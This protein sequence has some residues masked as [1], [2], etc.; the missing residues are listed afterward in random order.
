VQ[1]KSLRQILALV[2]FIGLLPMTLLLAL[3]IYQGQK[4]ARDESLADLNGL[5]QALSKQYEL[6]IADTEYVFQSLGGVETIKKGDRA[7]CESWLAKNLPARP[8]INTWFRL[9]P[10]GR[11]TCASKAMG[12]DAT[13]D[14]VFNPA[15]PKA[16]N[17]IRMSQSR[18]SASTGKHVL[19][20]TKTYWNDGAP[21]QLLVTLDVD[22]FLKAAAQYV[23]L[24]DRRV[25]IVSKDG[26]VLLQLPEY[27]AAY[28]GRAPSFKRIAVPENHPIV[29]E[30]K[31]GVDGT[32]R[33]VS[34]V[35]M[36]R[37]VDGRPLF[38]S[39]SAKPEAINARANWFIL[40]GL[41][42]LILGIIGVVI[43]QRFLFERYLAKPIAAIVTYSINAAQHKRNELIELPATAPREFSEIA[44]AV[45][46]MSNENEERS[47][48]LSE[49]LQNLERAQDIAKMG[50]WRIDLKSNTLDWSDGVY[51]LHKLERGTFEPSVERAI[52]L[53]HPED[54]DDV[55]RSIED[56][57]RK[58]QPF[59]FEKRIVRSD[60][61]YLYI[62]SRGQL[63][64]NSQGDPIAMFGTI[65]D[66]D[67]PKQAQRELKRAQSAAQR[68]ADTRASFV[69][70]V[71]HEVRTPLTAM[72]GIVD[73]FRHEELTAEQLRQVELLDASG[74]MLMTVI[75]DLLDSASVDAGAIRLVERPADPAA[76]VDSCYAIFQTAYRSTGVAFHHRS[77]GQAPQT[78]IFD[79][80]RTRQII[81][82]LL[83]NAFK[84]T[85]A[86]EIALETTFHADKML[87]SVRDTG[88][89]IAEAKQRHVFERF[90][91]GGDADGAQRPGTGLGLSIVKAIVEQMGGTIRLAS[92]QGQGSCFTVDIPFKSADAA[93]PDYRPAAPREKR[94]GQV[95]LVED[96]PVNQKLLMAFLKK[97]GCSFVVQN[98][99]QYAVEWLLAQRQEDLPVLA[100][101]DVNM[102]RLNGIELCEFIRT[103][104]PGGDQMPLYLVTADVIAGHDN[105][106]KKLEINGTIPK[107]I[108]FAALR[109]VVQ[110]YVA[111]QRARPAA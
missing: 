10:D 72:L 22:W 86:G 62:S 20:L 60:G 80:Q 84:H 13:L 33:F 100:L 56:A 101:I 21:F 88:P 39:V 69:A 97:I 99:G 27:N 28:R 82:N 55:Q 107:P 65:I 108:D 111:P 51:K 91:Q 3:L 63:T 95:L 78:A 64:F 73:G 7:A 25:F 43:A 98:D 89:G 44:H 48:A 74:Q 103:Q 24:Q 30:I 50:H 17:L 40:L 94:T 47:A 18:A 110:T 41:G 61:S 34:S 2:T 106:I 68:L 83:G 1:Q 52:E 90:H 15:D 32:A 109:E 11:V 49:A 38:L 54:R 9:S 96:N 76:L 31:N 67:A 66:I 45:T 46:T 105:A 93:T 59:E 36:H 5:T 14:V 53:Y 26:D 35:V 42:T 92:Q 37:F 79:A 77:S 87:V 6:Q 19:A 57:M 75:S 16:Y 102:P 29:H 85:R 8:G 104:L 58:G 81:F 12:D 4:S 71:T 70:S 23:P